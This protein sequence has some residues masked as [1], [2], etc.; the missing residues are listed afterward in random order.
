MNFSQYTNISVEETLRSLKTSTFGLSEKEAVLRIE[1]YGL[2]EIKSKNIN[3]I[4]VLL[5]Q[6]KS[7][8]TYL[9]LIAALVSVLIGQLVD[10]IAVF[11]FIVINVVIGFVQEYK[12]EKAVFMLQEFIPKKVK[13]LRDSKEEIIDEKF[14]VP[15]DIVLLEAGDL[16]PADLRVVNMHNFLVNES[17]LTGESVPVSKITEAFNSQESEIFKAKNIIFSGSLVVSGKAQA[18]A[19]ATGKDTVF[20]DIVKT[21][22][23][24][25]REST[26]EKSILFFCKLIMKIVATTI[27]LIF[28]ANILIKG[29]SNIFELLLF[30]VALIVSILPEALPAV[31][32]FALSGGSLRMAKQ[33][34]VVKRLSAIEDL[35]NIEILCTDKTGTLTQ[36]KPSLEKTVSSDKK[37]CFLYG[38]LASGGIFPA[39]A[40]SR[41]W[42][43]N[44]FDSALYQRA[45]EEILRES[46]KFKIVSELPFDSYRMRSAFLVKSIK[47]EAF[48]IVKGA[49]ESIIKNCRNFSA[50]GGP[51]SGWDKKEIQEDIDREGVEGKRVLAIAYKKIANEKRATNEAIRIEDEKGLTFLGYFVFDDPIKTTAKEAISLSKKLGIKIKIVTGDSKEVA[52]YVARKTGLVSGIEDT[53]SGQELEKLS[54][55]EFEDACESK[56]IFAR[57]SPD[58]KHNIIKSLQKKCEVGFMGEGVNDAPALKTADVGIA[59]VEASDIARE[60]ADVVLL[61]KDLRVIINGIKDGRTIFANINKYIKCALASN[62]GNFYSIA[63]ISLFINFL[64]MLPVQILLGNI[65]SDFPL[66]SIATDSVDIDELK[67]PKA[68]QLYNVLPLIISLALVSTVFDFIFFSIFH[69]QQPGVIQT[70]WFI[71]SILTELLLIYIIRTRGIFYKAKRPGFWLIFLTAI[72]GIFVVALPFLPIAQ[73]WFHF[74]VLP[75]M[76]L[77]IVFFLI[78]MYFIVSEIVKLIYFHYLPAGRQ[79]G[80]QRFL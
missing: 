45:T 54:K 11:A 15:G 50:Q 74:A 33:N 70:L 35:G 51:A 46:K 57:I 48:L 62:F 24:I 64:P 41:P 30:S 77:L 52:C 59:V 16:V 1:K 9:L 13:V 21:I 7:P 80:S 69:A 76:P 23:G 43:E 38:I 28:V 10:S 34:V 18:I 44:P 63:V 12:A 56:T 73:S 2:N 79:V 25:R 72:D 53:I 55:E 42:R 61:Q 67:K 60:A 6:L 37:K 31:V 47:N 49:P 19:I 20:G 71:E 36:N 22:S 39:T 8:F 32:T 17:A 78:G 26:Y 14:L 58:T 66:I 4:K 5:R 29:V 68:Y 65:L 40:G 3:A 75:I 27:I